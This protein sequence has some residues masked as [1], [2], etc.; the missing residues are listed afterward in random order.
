[1]KRTKAPA[2]LFTRPPASILAILAALVVAGLV[3]SLAP[4]AARRVAAKGS[5]TFKACPLQCEIDRELY[6][7]DPPLRGHDVIELQLRLRQL[8]L[9]KGKVDGV[10]GRS[11]AQ[12]VRRFQLRAGLRPDGV[13]RSETWDKLGEGIRAPVIQ[14]AT[15]RPP[16][17]VKLVVNVD[18]LTLTVYSG[19]KVYK[20]YPIAIG[21]WTTPTQLGEFTIIDKGYNPGGPFGTRW[22]GLNVP[23]GSYGIHGTNRPWSI[24]T[25]ASQGCI[26]MFN[27]HVEEVFDLVSIGTKVIITGQYLEEDLVTGVE[28]EL[29]PGDTGKDIRYVQYRLRQAGFDPGP[30]DGWFGPGMQNAVRRLQDFYCLPET[31]VVGVNELYVLGLR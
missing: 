22:L 26:R 2:R 25:A 13:V 29:R 1:M 21:E 4:P 11:T 10:F 5:A 6:L 30:I 24:G 28:R 27:E 7:E 19:E 18:E 23:W 20:T 9:Y 8:G 31:G 14:A 12:S 16:G 3:L 15:P 17:K